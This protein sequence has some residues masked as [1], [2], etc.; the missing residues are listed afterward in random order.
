MRSD[1]QPDTAATRVRWWSTTPAPRLARAILLAALSCYLGITA[2]NIISVGPSTPALATGLVTLAAVFVLQLLHCRP[3]AARAPLWSRVVSL[4]AQGVLTFLP[5]AFFGIMWGAMA[6]FLGG[7]LVLLLPPRVG[8]PLYGLTGLSLLVPG[9]VQK[10]PVVDL[11]Y[12]CQTTLLTGV[13]TYGLTRLAALVEEV[14]AARPEIAR[15]AANSERLRLARDLHDLLGYS[16][17]VIV[18]KSE[19]LQRLVRAQHELADQEVE[20]VLTISRQALADVRRVAQGYRD[21][22]LASEISLAR[23]V[24]DAADVVT[25]VVLDPAVEEIDARSRTVLATV[26]REG[27]TNLLRHS[28]ATRCGVTA[29]VDQ[30]TA[31]LTLLNDG[32]VADYRD[33]APD[34]GN[35]L[36]NLRQRLSEVGGRLITEGDNEATTDSEGWFRLVAEVPVAT[37]APAQASPAP[38]HQKPALMPNQAVS[39]GC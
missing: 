5:L 22:S 31:R 18:L 25:D 30:G 11:L 6:G 28:K 13:V 29:V 20:E 7:S 14:Y 3:G 35:G 1:A 26:L 34:S 17:S 12:M 33:P 37:E 27:V 38:D 21:M 39:G 16:L 8:W 15:M 10:M 9:L 23:S 2:I 24:L 19:L 36:N 32:A 4:T